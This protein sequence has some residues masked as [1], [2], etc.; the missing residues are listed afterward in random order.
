[1]KRGRAEPVSKAADV[2]PIL[3]NSAPFVS[4]LRYN[5]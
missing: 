1:M 2:Y 4:L 5:S 3:P